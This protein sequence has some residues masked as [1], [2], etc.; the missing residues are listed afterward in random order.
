VRSLVSLLLPA[1]VTT[2]ERAEVDVTVAV[3]PVEDSDRIPLKP[4]LRGL[5][6]GL[7][8]SVA[9]DTVD[10]IVSGPQTILNSLGP[11]DIFVILDLTGLLPGSHVL[12]PR[13]VKPDDIRL[14]GVLP[15]T[16]EVVIADP[17][18]P[19]PVTTPLPAVTA[20]SLAPP[21]SDRAPSAP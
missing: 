11:D 6:P 7:T 15:E 13:V 17:N 12:E 5:Q 9:L 10:V 21:G 4:T 8:A 20:T 16:I 3:T 19:T 18:T 2:T 1:G 14:E